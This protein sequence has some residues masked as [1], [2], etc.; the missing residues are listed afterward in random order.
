MPRV[1]TLNTFWSYLRRNISHPKKILHCTFCKRN[2]YWSWENLLV[3]QDKYNFSCTVKIFIVLYYISIWNKTINNYL[4]PFYYNWEKKRRKQIFSLIVFIFARNHL[5][6]LYHSFIT[7]F[8]HY[9][10]YNGL[11]LKLIIELIFWRYQNSKNI[12]CLN[13]LCLKL[14]CYLLH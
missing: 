12:F 6:N 7:S 9:I 5:H 1:K 8:V 2:G 14:I 11:V 4:L 10:Y 13:W 3:L